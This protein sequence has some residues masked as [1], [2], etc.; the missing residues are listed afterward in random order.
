MPL[1]TYLMR[2][3]PGLSAKMT[4]AARDQEREGETGRRGTAVIIGA[5]G[6]IGGA[7]VKALAETARYEPVIGLS[8][9]SEPSV[10]ITAEG[11]V[12]A[13]ARHVATTGGPLRLLVI[14]TGFLHD[15]HS[16]PERGLKDLDAGQLARA[17]AVNAIGP[18][19]VL[20]HFTP[21]L[22]KEGRSVVA[23]ISARVGSIG[24]NHLGGWHAYRASKA[25]LNQIVR[26]AAV[27]LK[28]TRPDAVCVALHPGTVDT[29]LSAPFSKSGLNVRP[30]AEA[31]RELLHVIDALRLHDTG[32]FFDYA[33]KP[34][35]W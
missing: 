6:G 25:A 19:L 1:A 27:E 16:R 35:P 3:K 17:Y 7:L 31:A 10:D 30:P 5:T 34:L 13:A 21:L 33:G 28:R 2:G 20:K 18:A 22:P 14:A 29:K 9:N 26:T 8:R 4:V 32:G 12:E 11:T 23:A 24:D 15:G